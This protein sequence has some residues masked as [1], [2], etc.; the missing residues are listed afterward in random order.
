MEKIVLKLLLNSR[1]Q[2]RVPAVCGYPIAVF[3]LAYKTVKVYVRSRKHQK[4]VAR[5][6]TRI[7]ERKAHDHRAPV[8]L[9]HSL[10]REIVCGD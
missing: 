8:L 1:G 3:D 5:V 9:L 2:Q 10:E 7:V 6:I 4:N